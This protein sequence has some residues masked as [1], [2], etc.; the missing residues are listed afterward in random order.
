MSE[1]I[2]SCINQQYPE[3][4][5]IDILGITVSRKGVNVVEI[6]AVHEVTVAQA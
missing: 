4:R 3:N 2:K 5:V 1:P 6:S